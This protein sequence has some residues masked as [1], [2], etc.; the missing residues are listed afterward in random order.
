MLVDL[1]VA[2]EAANDLQ[3]KIEA[4][5]REKVDAM[6]AAEWPVEGLGFGPDGVTFND[7]P[8]DQ[9]SSAEQ[10][11]IS[12]AIGASQNPKLNVMFIRDGSLLDADSLA[13]VGE[14]AERYGSQV[15]IERVG[16]GEECSVIIEDG[17]V[18]EARPREW[19]EAVGA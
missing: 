10:L 4:A 8:F 13:A 14:I 1:E 16:Y 2:T 6:L 9:C 18:V 12:T 15:W 19:R 11:R 3:L 5:R 17:T 7:L